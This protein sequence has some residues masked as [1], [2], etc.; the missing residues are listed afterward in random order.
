MQGAM[1]ASRIDEPKKV[2]VSTTISITTIDIKHR[3]LFVGFVIKVTV[4]THRAS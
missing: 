2:V 3:I 4:Q 1:D